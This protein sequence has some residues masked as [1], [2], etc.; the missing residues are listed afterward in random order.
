[1]TRQ[2]DEKRL[3][4]REE[5]MQAKRERERKEDQNGHKE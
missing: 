4:G 2:K 5:N 1:M 3:E